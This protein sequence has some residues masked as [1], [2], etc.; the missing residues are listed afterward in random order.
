[1]V[2]R[3]LFRSN[4][5]IYNNIAYGRPEATE[6][7]VRE[8]IRLAHLAQ[9]IEA[10][11]EGLETK[12]GER[13]LKLSGGEKQRI[14]LARVLL[15]NPPILLLDEATSSL[16]SVSEQAVLS[17][18][19]EV[20]RQRTTLVIAHRLSTVRDADQILVMEHG[21]IVERGSHEQLLAAQGAYARLWQQ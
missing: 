20:A 2:R 8:A 21:G 16:D 12:V 19:N 4:D 18:L 7:E 14:A 15:K 6:A 11:P 3:V 10:L 1:G 17:A 13:G 9:F 5:T